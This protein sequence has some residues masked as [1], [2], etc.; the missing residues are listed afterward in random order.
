MNKKITNT[1][2]LFVFLSL[3]IFFFSNQILRGLANYLIVEDEITFVEN[4]AVL[5]GGAFDRATHAAQLWNNNQIATILCTGN[6]LSPDLKALNI[7]TL[8]NQITK[9][10]LLNQGV[11]PSEIILINEGS[12]TFEEAEAILQYCLSNQL[13]E[14]LIISSKFHTRRIH[15]VF[16]K[17]FKAHGIKVFI[18][19]A[20]SS[21]YDEFQWWKSENG[22][23]ALNN[24]YIKLIYYAF[25]Y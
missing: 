18:S 13:K 11:S 3:I 8:E 1:I 24:E 9:T 19:G 17:K 23:I 15:Q 22:C 5:S 6:N 4:A 2:F 16:K 21:A 10:R 20:T 12:S 7:D 14:I 25:T